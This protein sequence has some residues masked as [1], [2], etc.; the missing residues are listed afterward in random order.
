MQFDVVF[1]GRDHN[2]NR[3][4]A[5]N[6]PSKVADGLSLPPNVLTASGVRFLNGGALQPADLGVVVRERYR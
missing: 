2:T 1:R 4:R 3:N 5:P 6:Y